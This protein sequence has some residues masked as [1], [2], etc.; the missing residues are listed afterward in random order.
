MLLELEVLLPEILVLSPDKNFMKK[1]L[2]RDFLSENARR[3]AESKPRDTTPPP[4]PEKKLVEAVE[5]NINQ[6]FEPVLG[7]APRIN[8][9]A[10]AEAQVIAGKKR[11]PPID[12]SLDIKFSRS[13]A[14]NYDPDF[15]AITGLV[16]RACSNKNPLWIHT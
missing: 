3:D 11:S 8:Y 5:S 15:E 7:H 10:S 16:F 6:A 4:I 14:P 2:R 13:K 1:N 12:P 9:R